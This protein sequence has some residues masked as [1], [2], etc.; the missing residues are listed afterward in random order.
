[1]IRIQKYLGNC[2]KLEIHPKKVTIRKFR[3]GADFLGYIV[4]PNYRLL[5]TKTRKRIFKKFEKK[6]N[7]F[8]SGLISENNLSQSLNSYLGVLSHADSYKFQ[9]KLKNLVRFGKTV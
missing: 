2:L 7:N 1:L 8:K 9:K 5:R 4:F 3:Q 6:V